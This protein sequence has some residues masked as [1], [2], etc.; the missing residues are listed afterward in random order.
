MKIGVFDS[1]VGGLTVL[2]AMAK[3]FPS[4]EFL[5]VG[6][7]ARLP[8]GNKSTTTVRKYSEEI[9]DFLIGKKVDAIVIACNTA[10]SQVRESQW[11]GI[12]TYN[13]IGPGAATAVKLTKTKRVGVLGTRTTIATESYSK[14]IKSIDSSIDVFSQS[15][16]LLVPLA[17]EGWVN[18][19]IADLVIQRYVKPLLDQNIDTLILGCTHYPLLKDAIQRLCGYEIRLVDSGLAIAQEIGTL[20]NGAAKAP[21]KSN[22]PLIHFFATDLS[23]HTQ[24]IAEKILDP[25]KVV[26]FTEIKL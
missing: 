9:M 16:P 1:G 8:Y 12:P 23:P 3:A 14:A 6:D 10:S 21:A 17:E 2:S 13:V 24:N 19:P 18:D 20:V 26:E 25:M 22:Q 5:Y 11:K 15:C 7:T 4:V